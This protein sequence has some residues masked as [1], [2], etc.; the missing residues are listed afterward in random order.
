MSGFR[1]IHAHFIY[2]IDDGP[3][4]R[5]DMEAM[6]DAAHADGITTLF[7]TPHGTP[8]VYPFDDA[9]YLQRLNEARAY[10]RSRNYS[11]RLYSGAEIMYTPVIANASKESIR[12][13]GNSNV[14]LMEFVPDISFPEMET[15]VEMMEDLGYTVMMAHIE[16]YD[17]LYRSGNAYR[18]KERHHVRYQINCSSLITGRG[19]WKNRSIRKWLR[20]ELID[21]L[22]T[23][24]HDCVRRPF[25]MKAAHAILAEQV[26]IRY[27]DMLT[28][29]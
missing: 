3:R 20:D 22:S 1:D 11:M 8:G 16:R 23:D 26:G 7:A 17:C 25:R 14:V 13:L 21:S 24:A 28:G 5:A 9:L 29:L 12:T 18:L 19:F 4:T 2:G 10:C 15:A 6:L 27:A